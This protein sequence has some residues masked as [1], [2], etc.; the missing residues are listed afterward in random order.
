[1]RG[2]VL[3]LILIVAA[4][5]TTSSPKALSEV[6]PSEAPSPSP[7]QLVSPSP[8]QS[9]PPS[10]P[11]ASGSPQAS[12][13]PPSGLLFAALES[14]STQTPPDTVVIVGLDGFATPKALCRQRRRAT[15]G[16]GSGSG[17]RSLLHR[18]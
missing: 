9:S 14:P 2:S 17:L 13:Q 1:M 7:T 6:S 12:S 11:A 10:T 15:T 3:A 18:R 4:C 16:C 5:G 8:T